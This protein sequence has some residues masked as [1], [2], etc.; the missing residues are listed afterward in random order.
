M[1]TSLYHSMADVQMT[2]SAVLALMGV[3][4]TDTFL[5]A[6]DRM[7][8]INNAVIMQTKQLGRIKTLEEKLHVSEGCVQELEHKLAEQDCIIANLV[9]DNLKPPRQHVPD[10]THQQHVNATCSDQG[11]AG[12]GGDVGLWD[13]QG[14]LGGSKHGGVIVGSQ[15][16]GCF[17][18]Q[19]GRL[20]WGHR[21]WGHWCIS[22]GEYKG[23]EPDA[24]G[25]WSDRGDGEGGNRGWC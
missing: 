10:C 15:D 25:R 9:G 12:S 14:S 23:G 19:L 6:K 21:Q 7:H 22:R 2:V 18:K 13:H 5:W 3:T 16:V 20:G 4:I 1:G 24:T 8:H 17:W 11:A